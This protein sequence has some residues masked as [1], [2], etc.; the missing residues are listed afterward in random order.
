MNSY[1]AVVV[2][3]LGIFIFIS[4]SCSTQPAQFDNDEIPFKDIINTVVSSNAFVDSF[5]VYVEE[6]NRGLSPYIF[7]GEFSQQKCSILLR[8]TNVPDSVIVQ[9]ATLTLGPFYVYGSPGAGFTAAVHE[10]ASTWD[11][12]EIPDI[13]YDP[14]AAASFVVDPSADVTDSVVIPD[15][16]VQ[17][18]V[19]ARSDTMLSNYGILI[20]FNT[21]N[22]AK[23]YLAQTGVTLTLRYSE[24]ETEETSTHH[25]TADTYI[26]EG[27]KDFSPDFLVSNFGCHRI[28]M[29]FGFPAIPEKVVINYAELVMKLDTDNSFIGPEEMQGFSVYRIDSDSWQ[30]DE[31][32]YS[33]NDVVVGMLDFN[34]DVPEARFVI[35]QF[36]QGWISDAAENRGILLTSLRENEGFSRYTFAFDTAD[37][38]MQPFMIIH[39]STFNPF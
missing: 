26:V 4:A 12:N 3:I 25:P 29:R 31:L 14:V 2:L 19:D 1:K 21:A 5:L 36:V 13:S 8:F 18:W 38:L 28:I 34:T 20:T 39:Y 10:I 7:L 6:G 9:S 24:G 11:E 33:E 30:Q 17:G 23:Q 15:E 16:I 22:F 35:T 32:T 27:Q 37:S